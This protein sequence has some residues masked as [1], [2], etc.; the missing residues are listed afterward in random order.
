MLGKRHIKSSQLVKGQLGLLNCEKDKL[1]HRHLIHITKFGE[2]TQMPL[3]TH[4]SQTW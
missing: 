4:F 3:K 1:G 2:K